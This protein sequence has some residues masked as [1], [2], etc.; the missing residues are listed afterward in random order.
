MASADAFYVV[1]E[2]VISTALELQE[3]Q[4]LSNWFRLLVF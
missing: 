1:L 2:R 4:S 3:Y